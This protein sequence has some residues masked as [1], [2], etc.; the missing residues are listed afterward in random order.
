MRLFRGFRRRLILRTLELCEPSVSNELS[1]VIV[2][3]GVGSGDGDRGKRGVGLGEM[4]H[5]RPKGA[6]KIYICFGY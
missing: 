1:R 3:L 2:D 6:K 4:P 5:L